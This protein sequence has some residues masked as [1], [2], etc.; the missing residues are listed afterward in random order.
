MMQTFKPPTSNPMKP[1]C[2]DSLIAIMTP[3]IFKALGEPNRIS[4]LAHLAMGNKEQTVSE[5][6][7]KSPLSISVVSRHLKIL[8]EANILHSS[9][10]GKEVFYWVNASSL[11]SVLREMADAIDLCCP[12]G[13]CNSKKVE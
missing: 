6:A 10:R 12:N 5:V 7:A 11:S 2:C 1:Q 9:K 4:I 3:A 8:K 13:S